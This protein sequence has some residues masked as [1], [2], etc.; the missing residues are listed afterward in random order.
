DA[1]TDETRQVA[2]LLASADARVE[3][4]RHTVNRGHVATYNE[5]L[6]WATGSYTLLISADDLLTPGALV[7]ARELLDAYPDVGFVYGWVISFSSDD[8]PS[9]R[10]SGFDGF[11]I[12]SGKEWLKSICA[13]GDNLITSP[14]VV[15]RTELLRKLGGYRADLPHTGDMELWMRLAT[16]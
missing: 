5:G 11:E 16:H 7:R 13:E 1:S 6:D 14:E 4:R 3:V 8:G 10:R 12:V 15:A 9:P 2:A